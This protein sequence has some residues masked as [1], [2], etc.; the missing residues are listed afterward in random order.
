MYALVSVF[1][2]YLPN[3]QIWVWCVAIF[4]GP[5][6]ASL[7]Y[8]SFLLLFLCRHQNCTFPL[9]DCFNVAYRCWS[10][11]F[12]FSDFFLISCLIH[13][14][15]RSV[16]FSLHEFVYLLEILL[17]LVLRLIALCSDYV[18]FSVFVK[19]WFMSQY[20]AY[21]R[22]TWMGRWVKDRCPLL[23]G[24][25][26]FRYQLGPFDWMRLINSYVSG[27]CSDG[28]SIGETGII[29]TTHY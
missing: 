10:G 11:M 17:L 16:L 15:F 18:S 9:R 7:S 26:D 29:E 20:V 8:L 4:P 14:S 12:S 13:S 3:L 28:L 22:E 1:S 27:F 19:I 24:G 2:F 25:V 23:F 6:G 21:F 5:L